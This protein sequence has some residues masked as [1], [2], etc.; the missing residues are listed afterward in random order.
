MDPTVEKSKCINYQIDGGG[1]SH[2]CKKQHGLRQSQLRCQIVEDTAVQGESV[3][4]EKWGLDL[5]K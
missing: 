2:S 3:I 1:E 4:V 5:S